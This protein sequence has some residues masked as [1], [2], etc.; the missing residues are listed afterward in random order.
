MSKKKKLLADFTE[1]QELIDRIDTALKTP[2]QQSNFNREAILKAGAYK[3]M[4]HLVRET[5][6]GKNGSNWYRWS[7][8]PSRHSASYYLKPRSS[9]AG[10]LARGWVSDAPQKGRGIPSVAQCAYKVNHTVVA[11]QGK[12]LTMTFYNT[13]PFARAV[14]SG[15]LVRMPYFFD[16]SKPGQGRITGYVPGQWFTQ[17]AIYRAEKD[18][19]MHMGYEAVRQLKQVVKKP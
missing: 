11:P 6:V 4:E 3:Q 18:V 2:D 5:P 15:H 1:V 17:R 13:A 7:Y 16:G 19:K 9:V 12:D 14:E 10:T 8:P